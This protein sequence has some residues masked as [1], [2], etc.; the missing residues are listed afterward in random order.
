MKDLN[1][2]IGFSVAEST[3]MDQA[4]QPIPEMSLEETY[5]DQ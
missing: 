3:L 5:I 4:F 1:N 2:N